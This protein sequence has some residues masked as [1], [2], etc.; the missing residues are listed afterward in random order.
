MFTKADPP[1]QVVLFIATV[2]RYEHQN[3]PPDRFLG[4]IAIKTLCT[5]VPARDRHAKVSAEDRV[6][7]RGND[8]SE[9]PL[10]FLSA[11]QFGR[12]IDDAEHAG[13]GT[14]LAG[15]QS[16]MGPRLVP[17]Q[18]NDPTKRA[19]SPVWRAN[20]ELDTKPS[21]FRWIVPCE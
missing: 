14:I 9:P 1:K 6:I 11:P 5:V 19:I 8:R 21:L 17:A 7:A 18:S 20:P 4:G 12:L 2:V 15:G 16:E 13:D 3:G 10:G